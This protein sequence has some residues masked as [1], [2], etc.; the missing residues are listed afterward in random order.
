MCSIEM[1]VCR[2]EKKLTLTTR[3]VL[4]IEMNF[5]TNKKKFGGKILVKILYFLY[6][7]I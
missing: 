5:E 3:V 2:D 4:C 7:Q 1:G 6:T